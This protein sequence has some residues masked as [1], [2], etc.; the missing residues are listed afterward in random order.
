[1]A[2]KWATP[3]SGSK[4]LTWPNGEIHFRDEGTGPTL[5][6]IHGIADSL[7]T[8]D[9]WTRRLKDRHRIIRL[10]LPGFG[11]STLQSDSV[12][13]L[14]FIE[15]IQHVLLHLDVHSSLK[16]AGN[17]LGGY[18]AAYLASLR[19]ELVESLVLLDP[20]GYPLK[21]AP[22]MIEASRKPLLKQVAQHV[23]P[24]ALIHHTTKSLFADKSVVTNE[25]LE[26][27][28]DLSLME[29]NRESYMRIFQELEKRKHEYPGFVAKVLSPTL[30]IWGEDDPWIPLSH[31][32]QWKKDLTFG[33]V[34]IYSHCG[35]MPQLEKPDESAR[36]ANDFFKHH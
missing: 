15:A 23:T 28:F 11:L 29:G 10:D 5:L 25:M 21:K 2:Q 17:S 6:L 27:F 14:F 18:L 24:F 26:R 36:D 32:E 33:E 19:P 1:V 20:A 35:H 13:P 9:R 16:V 31:A 12:S 4:F 30:V 22:W 7:H 34:R 3:E 8:W